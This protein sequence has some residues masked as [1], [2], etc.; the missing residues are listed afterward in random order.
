[1][2][3]LVKL[4]LSQWTATLVSGSL[5]LLSVLFSTHS[6]SEIIKK[7]KSHQKLLSSA[8][9]FVA[10]AGAAPYGAVGKG[11]CAEMGLL[12]YWLQ[13]VALCAVGWLEMRAASSQRS[14]MGLMAQWS[15]LPESLRG[16]LLV[17]HRYSTVLLS[18]CYSTHSCR[19]R[20]SLFRL[21]KWLVGSIQVWS[22]SDVL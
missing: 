2:C 3:N 8:V 11:V 5:T 21:V 7:K 1:M 20:K 14:D 6:Y 16:W 12:V 15:C 10:V 18:H 13:A 4:N 19:T 9:S 22:P 17:P